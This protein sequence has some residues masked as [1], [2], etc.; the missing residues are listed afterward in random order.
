MGYAVTEVN[1]SDVKRAFW[2]ASVPIDIGLIYTD[3]TGAYNDVFNADVDLSNIDEI[4]VAFTTTANSTLRCTIGGAV[5][6]T[7]GGADGYTKIIDTSGISG[8]TNIKL[9]VTDAGAKTNV[10]NITMW[11][12][13]GS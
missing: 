1:I 4:M 11:A 6:F 10:Q 7:Q 8:I 3:G 2:E 12:S 9:E 5:K 13:I